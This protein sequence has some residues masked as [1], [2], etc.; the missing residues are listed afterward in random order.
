MLDKRGPEEDNC[1][2]FE[3]DKD[4]FINVTEQCV[5][6]FCQRSGAKLLQLRAMG[7][8]DFKFKRGTN[9]AAHMTCCFH[10]ILKYTGTPPDSEQSLE[11]MTKT[12]KTRKRKGTMVVT[13][14]V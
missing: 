2:V 11:V 8:P 4:G 14:I 3:K 13:A 1:S 5:L 10:T 12:R 7:N 9:V 6:Q